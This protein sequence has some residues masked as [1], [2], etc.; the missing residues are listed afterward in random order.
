MEVFVATIAVQGEGGRGVQ[1]CVQ[2]SGLC[3]TVDNHK[4]THLTRMYGDDE[5]LQEYN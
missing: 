2:H 4:G 5:T 1:D 3:S